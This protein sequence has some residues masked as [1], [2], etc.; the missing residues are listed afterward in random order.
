MMTV[1][2]V[3]IVNVTSYL[4]RRIAKH[5]ASCRAPQW[6]L[7]LTVTVNTELYLLSMLRQAERLTGG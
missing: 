3:E 4:S 6:R 2:I 7:L 1:Y 5:L